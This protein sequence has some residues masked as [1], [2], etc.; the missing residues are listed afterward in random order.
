[1]ILNYPSSYLNP[2][3]PHYNTLPLYVGHEGLMCGSS[4]W[5]TWDKRPEWLEYTGVG[6][7][8]RI[9]K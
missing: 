9:L 6:T 7:Y 1:M 8:R 4:S 5:H 2:E 3:H